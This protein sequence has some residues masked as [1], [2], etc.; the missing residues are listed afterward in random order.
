MKPLVYGARLVTGAPGAGRAG[1][2]GGGGALTAC[3][4]LL[5]VS[6]MKLMSASSAAG[7]AMFWYV[8]VMARCAAS[9]RQLPLRFASLHVEENRCSLAVS[10]CSFFAAPCVHA[11]WRGHHGGT[12]DLDLTWAQDREAIGALD[13]PMR[14]SLRLHDGQ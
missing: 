14:S 2:G 5:H 7:L 11:S 1:A 13:E 9:Y 4:A 8:Y 6:D 3:S 10:G 12:P